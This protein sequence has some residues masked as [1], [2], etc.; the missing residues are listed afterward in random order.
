MSHEGAL[1][2]SDTLAQSRPANFVR[3]EI[4][5][6][7]VPKG[8][9]R[10]APSGHCYTPAKTRQWERSARW[11]AAL[12]MRGRMPMTGPVRLRVVAVLPVPRSWPEKRRAA[13]LA[14]A[15][16][17]TGKP[18]ADNVAKAAGD[19]IEGI[20]FRSDSQVVEVVATK[21]YGDVPKVVIEVEPI[22]GAT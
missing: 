3:V 9:P 22:G 5:G 19:S 16:R 4:L 18:D 14:G 2:A 12:A 13:A 10:F 21:V 11:Q 8:R 6:M 15:E 20:A 1:N 7:P 17:P